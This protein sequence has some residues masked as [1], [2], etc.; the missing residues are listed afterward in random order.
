MSAKAAE[1]FFMEILELHTKLG[2]YL[3][4]GGSEQDVVLVPLTKYEI[5][6][7]MALLQELIESVP[8]PPT[9]EGHEG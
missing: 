5:A 4:F 7:T 8:T 1:Q 9:T 6:S 2:A 3:S